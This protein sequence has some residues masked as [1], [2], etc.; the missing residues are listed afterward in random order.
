M[1]YFPLVEEY[2][3]KENR[4]ADRK[5]LCFTE[6]SSKS[7]QVKYESFGN[8]YLFLR[9]IRGVK[10]RPSTV[11]ATATIILHYRGLNRFTGLILKHYPFALR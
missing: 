6:S 2:I 11:R 9:N 3:V 10:G 5:E 7:L 1:Y 8:S 4:S